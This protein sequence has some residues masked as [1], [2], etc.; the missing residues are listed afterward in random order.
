MKIYYI[1]LLL[2]NISIISESF[3]RIPILKNKCIPAIILLSISNSNSNSISNSTNSNTDSYLNSINNNQYKSIRS[4]ILKNDPNTQDNTIKKLEKI[5]NNIHK[6]ISKKNN[7][8][9]QGHK[10]TYRA[11]P[12]ATF[13]TIFL[14]INQIQ[15]VYISYNKDRMI[16]ELLNTKYVYYIKNK[17]DYDKMEKFI[18]IIPSKIK[19]IIINDVENTMNDPFGHLYCDP[20]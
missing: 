1:I 5:Q 2:L 9:E 7:T 18:F 17:E 4:E 13:D 16:F 19:I 3:T 20:K 6:Y 12:K 8:I 14:N 15:K 11:I 10:S